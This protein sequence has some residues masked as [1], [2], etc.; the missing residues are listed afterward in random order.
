MNARRLKL[1][2][3]VA[4]AALGALA[5]LAWTQPWFEIVLVGGQSLL[6][7]GQSAVPGLSGLGLAALALAGALAI[8][9]HGT[10]IALGVVEV[11]LGA[12]VAVI[13]ALALADPVAASAPTV[14]DATAVAGAQS[15]A[16]LVE[17]SSASAWPWL[18]IVIGA[19]LALTGL[20]V[21]L[22][23]HRWP[24]PVRKYEST[25]TDEGS[26]GAWD[27]LSDGDDPTAAP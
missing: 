12:A 13:S 4:G 21:A 24:G 20:A 9:G 1:S 25:R 8:A 27:A 5:L 10:R 2:L 17:S 22:T 6:V 26:A 7:D 18:A 3:V 16:A 11:V 19:L 14:T 15:V 23:S